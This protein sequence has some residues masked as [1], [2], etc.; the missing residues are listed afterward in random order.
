MKKIKHEVLGNVKEDRKDKMIA[1][2][3]KSN[4]RTFSYG[5]TENDF[6]TFRNRKKDMHNSKLRK[7]GESL[8]DVLKS[9][10]ADLTNLPDGDKIF[11][12]LKNMGEANDDGN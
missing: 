6:E 8:A 1:E 7:D 12:I 10:Q 11:Q 2:Q 3:E 4:T 9:G 5:F